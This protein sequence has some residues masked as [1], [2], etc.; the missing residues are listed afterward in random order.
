[1]EYVP[2]G[3]LTAAVVLK[4]VVTVSPLTR[5][6]VVPVKAGLAVP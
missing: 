4:V 1:M 5:P 2:T 3:E 6:V